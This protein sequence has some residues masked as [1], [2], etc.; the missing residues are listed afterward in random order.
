M[1]DEELLRRASLGDESAFLLLYE[2]HRDAVYGFA[3]RLLG[4]RSAA[5]DVAHDCFLSL[6]QKPMR[7]ES[8]RASLRT[9]LYAAARNLAYKHFRRAGQE[10]QVEE[11]PEE[12][13]AVEADEPLRKVLDDELAFEV[14]KAIEG[15]PPLQ[16][17]AVI[18]F[19]YERL[20]LAEIAVVTSAD[21]GTVKARLYR[22]R[23]NLKRRLAPYLS[24][25]ASATLERR[26][27]D[28]EEEDSAIF[29]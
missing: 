27:N 8:H 2:R 19:E 7:F 20:T 14:R 24:G 4:S 6:M 1:T 26:E 10:I 22:A 3:Y 23:Q 16:R 5:E 25:K 13:F 12:S 9:Y 11:L 29:H 21:L 18:L 15:L 28:W 17:E